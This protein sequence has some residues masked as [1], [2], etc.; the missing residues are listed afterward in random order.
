MPVTWRDGVFPAACAATVLAVACV[1]K[2]PRSPAEQAADQALADRV[3]A[4]LNDDSVHYYRHVDVTV[5]GGVADLSGY[6]WSTEALYRARQ[7][8]L[9][10]P[11]VRRVVTSH[12]ELE[13]QG[14][15]N[16][17]AR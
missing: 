12:L 1:T 14:S 5:Q 10:V 13:R 16:G 2:A 15:I 6:V 9:E 11:G 3:Y 17:R 7:I 8:T 4:T